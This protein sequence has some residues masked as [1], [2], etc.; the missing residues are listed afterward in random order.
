MK[1]TWLVKWT[2]NGK[3][4]IPREFHPTRVSP[5]AL[6]ETFGVFPQV[7]ISAMSHS[8]VG[9]FTF[10]QRVEVMMILAGVTGFSLVIT[11]LQF[12][13]LPITSHAQS[14]PTDG[15]NYTSPGVYPARNCSLLHILTNG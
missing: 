5:S 12:F 13:L 10:R 3:T 1:G 6:S 9:Q 7:F 4:L 2:L 14:T 8:L 15:H 11:L